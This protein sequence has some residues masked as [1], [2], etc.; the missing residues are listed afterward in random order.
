MTDANARIKATHM[1]DQLEA[2]TAELS[3]WL[4]TGA[5]VECVRCEQMVPATAT[6]D[7]VRHQWSGRWCE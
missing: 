4:A 6:S 5:E 3:H 2:A 7:P 1:L